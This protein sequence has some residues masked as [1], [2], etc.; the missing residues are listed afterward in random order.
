MIMRL[1]QML[2]LT[3]KHT[4]QTV[5]SPFVLSHLKAWL[6]DGDVSIKNIMCPSLMVGSPHQCEMF[7]LSLFDGM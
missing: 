1:R 4:Y 7:E 2:D 6:H 5:L 3:S